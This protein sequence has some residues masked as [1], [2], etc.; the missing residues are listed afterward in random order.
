MRY[1]ATLVLL[2]AV[3]TISATAT[4][5]YRSEYAAYNT[6]FSAGNIA[7][8]LTHGEAAWRAAETELGAHRTTA[9]LAYNF[10]RL[11]EYGNPSTM[12]EAYQRVAALIA[13]GVSDLDAADV[14]LRT[15]FAAFRVEH[16]GKNANTLRS[17]LTR[18]AAE[19]KPP[20][21]AT[22]LALQ[23]LAKEGISKTRY[24]IAREDAD[25]AVLALRQVS[26]PAVDL[27]SRVMT[28]A[29]IAH[30]APGRTSADI[31]DAVLLLKSVIASYPPQASIDAVD[32]NLALA[33][34]LRAT[35]KALVESDKNAFVR[36]VMKDSRLASRDDLV[37][38]F[39]SVAREGAGVDPWITF[40]S[41]RPEGVECSPEWAARTP[42][43]FPRQARM[44]LEVGAVLLGYDLN[45]TG[46]ERVVVLSDGLGG[47]AFGEV[48]AKAATSWR[49]AKPLPKEC[50]KNQISIVRFHFL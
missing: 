19:G 4:A 8:A 23:E 43:V 48:A 2:L 9:I 5:D 12:L 42:P 36:K 38:A 21:E 34:S 18:Q 35:A 39:E 40:T 20:S 49:L 50:W 29:A 22:V 33:I 44:N 14:E 3:L 15:A 45:E 46:V 32:S 1:H 6:A 7:A 13:A 37:Q 10:A 41:P 16:S 28:L 26:E 30:L 24:T 27:R 17:V 31:A 11:A 47:K 25:A